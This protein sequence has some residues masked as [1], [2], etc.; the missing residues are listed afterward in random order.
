MSV[1]SAPDPASGVPTPFITAGLFRFLNELNAHNDRA[2]FEANKTRYL[3]RV[4]DPILGFVAAIAP[5]LKAVSP[6][7]VA[8][9][10]PSGGSLLRIYRDTRFSRDKAPRGWYS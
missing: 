10:R 4:R 3:T 2:W 1:P 9:P 7:V 8:D 6:H 5:K